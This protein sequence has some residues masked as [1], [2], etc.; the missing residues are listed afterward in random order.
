M[1]TAFAGLLVLLCA[2]VVLVACA[3]DRDGGDGPVHTLMEQ[4]H[5]GRGSPYDQLRRIVEGPGAP[6]PV[7]EQTVTGFG[8]MVRVLLES[9]N[10]DIRTSA[11]GYVDAIGKIVA[12]VKRRD[13][14]GVRTGFDS[15]RQSCGDCHYEGGVGGKLEWEQGGQEKRGRR[16]EPEDD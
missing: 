14:K 16:P 4:T 15:L 11:D 1:K 2:G 7:V 12:A 10:D 13:A 9:G 3:D 8:P 6:W 5:E